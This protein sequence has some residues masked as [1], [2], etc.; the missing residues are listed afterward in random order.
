VT[1]L[2]KGTDLKQNVRPNIIGGSVPM[3]FRRYPSTRRLFQ[4]VVRSL[5]ALGLAAHSRP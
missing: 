1:E 2:E 4:R 5:M 3:G